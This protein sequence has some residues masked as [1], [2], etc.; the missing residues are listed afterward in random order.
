MDEDEIVVHDPITGEIAHIPPKQEVMLAELKKFIAY[1]NA[2]END[3]DEF[4]HPVIKATILHFWFAY[5]HPFADGNGR[6]SR[7]I[8]YWFLLKRNYWLI[9]YI[10]VSRAIKQSRKGYD[11]AFL[12]SEND[13]NDMTYFML[14]IAETFKKSILQFMEHFEKKKK[15]AD[16]LKK[17]T[18][19]LG[20]FNVRQIA[21]LRY[22]L[23]HSDEY[24][25]VITHQN[26]HGISRPSAYND[27]RSLVK[28]GYMTETRKG[29]RFVYMPNIAKIKAAFAK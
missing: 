19:I 17:S 14:Y 27:L 10:S 15:E 13:D 28:K 20:Q 18:S 23:A 16:E 26:K 3:E 8:F 25:D 5:L 21:L 12:F 1:A 29:K 6:S 24:T 22:F 9:E 11:N 2:S 7:A 4:T